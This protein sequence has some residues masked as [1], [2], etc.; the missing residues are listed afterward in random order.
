[1]YDAYLRA[2]SYLDY[3]GA[4]TYAYLIAVIV[5]ALTVIYIKAERGFRRRID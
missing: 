2:F 1:M 4:A 3:S 5:M